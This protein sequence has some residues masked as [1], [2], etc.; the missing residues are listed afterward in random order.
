MSSGSSSGSDP[1]AISG[2]APEPTSRTVSDGG[3]RLTVL[4]SGTLLPDRRHRSAA[5]LVE[6]GGRRCLVDCGAG[7]VHGFDE[8][9]VAWQ[10]LDAVV[11]SHYHTD[12]IGDLPALLFALKHGVQPPRLE[13]LSILGPPGL[14]VRLEAMAEAFGDHVEDPGFPLRTEEI[15]RRGSWQF[16]RSDEGSDPDEEALRVD[17]HPTPHTDESVAHRWQL[18]GHVIAYTGDTGPP[19]ADLVDFLSDA[20]VLIAETSLPDS[21]DMENH[22]TPSRVAALARDAEPGVLIPTHVYPQLGRDG[23][24]GLLAGAGYEGRIEMG[25][26][27]LVV[28]I[29]IEGSSDAVRSEDG[30]R[31]RI[32]RP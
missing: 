3:L 27:G 32:H 15:G 22:L 7:T 12:H 21:T 24:P 14:L 18:G 25:V 2:P 30:E 11:F 31:I 29:G 4:G 9:G 26:D 28:E 1:D 5:Y 23:L 8:H 6:G 19:D 20:D 16:A 17:F 10:L 13:P